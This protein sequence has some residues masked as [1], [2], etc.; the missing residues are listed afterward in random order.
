[1]RFHFDGKEVN[2]VSEEKPKEVKPTRYW[3]GF[4]LLQFVFV[5]VFTLGVASAV[6]DLCTAWDMP[7]SIFSLDATIYG[8]VGVLV[9]EVFARISRKW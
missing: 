8:G 1:M 7:F 2:R 5:A 6:G 3:V 9:S 4:R